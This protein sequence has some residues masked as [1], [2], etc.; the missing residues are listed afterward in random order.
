M[1]SLR[2]FVFRRYIDFG[3]FESLREMKAMIEREIRRKGMDRNIKLGP[4]GLRDVEF[5]VQLLQMVHGRADEGVQGRSTLQS[6]ASLGEGGYI[7]REHV[8]EMDEAYR[9]LRCVEHRLQLH[10]LR[11]TQVL[12]T[13][14]SDLRR[15][16]RSLGLSP[17]EFAKLSMSPRP[18]MPEA[19][20]SRTASSASRRRALM[21]GAA[22]TWPSTQASAVAA[23][24][25]SKFGW[26]GTIIGAAL[27]TMIITGGSASLNA[28]LQNAASRATE[29]TSVRTVRA[30]VQ[31]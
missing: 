22:W 13:A 9:F 28:Y 4:G 3:A 10:R 16:S 8:S 12:P 25:T 26:A 11:R 2:P 1:A 18:A 21:W 27:T 7:S 5:T 19:A 14:A 29:S 24:V 15:L 31:P 20:A 30:D 17:D 23:G 6:L